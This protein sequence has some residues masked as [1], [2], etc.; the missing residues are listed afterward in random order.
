MEA[1]WKKY[2]YKQRSLGW[3]MG[4]GEK[5]LLAWK[6]WFSSIDELERNEYVKNNPM[7]T[8]WF[9]F[10][11]LIMCQDFLARV[12]ISEK[13]DLARSNYFNTQIKLAK[14]YIDINEIE[15]AKLILND[16]LDNDSSIQ[17]AVSLL[18]DLN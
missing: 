7:P 3:R 15:Q 11:D 2:K 12:E 8:D 14:K 6:K 10:Y 1:P 16:L 5:Y 13:V 4:E 18:K 17:E 9:Y